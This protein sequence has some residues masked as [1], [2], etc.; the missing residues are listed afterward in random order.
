MEFYESIINYYD[1][2]FP[3]KEQQARFVTQSF[4][5]PENLSLL[6]I[7]CGTGSLSTEL[8]K[9]FSKVVAIDLDEAMIGRAK[10]KNN[11]PV[12]FSKMNML[13]IEEEFGEQ[14]FDAVICFGNTLVHVTDPSLIQQ[15]F[16]QAKK[17]LQSDGKL[18]FQIIN[19]DRIIDQNIKAL[20]TIENDTVRFVRN[21]NYSSPITLIDFETTLLIKETDNEIQNSVQLYPLRK[22]EVEV[23]LRRAGFTKLTFYGNFKREGLTT[24]SQPLIV[25]ATI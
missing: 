1:H 3:L 12:S 18:L 14:A 10:K 24:D 8:S 15:F 21:Y 19:Y 13:D 20:P 11:G 16:N 6:D 4:P 23:M 25:E 2:I 22:A 17:I 5:H 7:G 9:T